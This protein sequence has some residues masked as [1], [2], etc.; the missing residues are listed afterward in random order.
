VLKFE[1]PGVDRDH[2]EV[3]RENGHLIVRAETAKEEET[4]EGGYH[5]RERFHGHFERTVPLPAEV[6]DEEIRAKFE[7]GVLEIRAPKHEPEPAG[8]RIEVQ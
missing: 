5:R 4:D 7:D 1:L 2:L 8:R 6:K 3:T